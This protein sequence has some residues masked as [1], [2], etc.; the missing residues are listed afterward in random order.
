MSRQRALR[1]GA[2][3]SALLGL[4]LLLVVLPLVAPVAHAAQ[5]G[6][7]LGRPHVSA[8]PAA[9]SQVNVTISTTDAAAFMPNSIHATSGQNLTITLVNNGTYGHTFT[10]ARNGSEELPLNWTPPQLSAYFTAHPPLLNVSMPPKSSATVN[11]T[12]NSSMAGGHFEFVSILPYQFQAGMWGFLNVT[13]PVR[14]ALTFYV[15]ASDSYKFVSNALDASAVTQFPIQVNVF[16]GTLGVLS[17][18][19][20][21][22]PLP[23]YNLS[24][25]NYSAFFVQHPPLVNIPVPLSAGAYTN[26][27]F[28]LDEPGAYE[29]IC[30]VQGHFASGMYGFL[31]AGVPVVSSS[32]AVVST[33]LVQ[34][35]VLVGGGALLGIGLILAAAA[36]IS[37]RLPPTPPTTPSH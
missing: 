19:F 14:S 4:L 23:D 2:V 28:V 25:S 34:T 12:V 22:S 21:L 8:A 3:S 11:L 35:E 7:D 10:M 26:G 13:P 37:G 29:F 36:S 31:Y 16:L 15:N 5:A 27:S 33:A 20:T 1:R 17:H 9:P 18:T 30:T 32:T 24:V 6:R